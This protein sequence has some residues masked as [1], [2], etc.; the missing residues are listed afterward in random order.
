MCAM[1][2]GLQPTPTNNLAVRI[3]S[4]KGPKAAREEAL[5]RIG[6]GFSPQGGI[7]KLPKPVKQEAPPAEGKSLGNTILTGGQGGSS[8]TPAQRKSLLGS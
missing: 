1:F 3:F 2:F 4:G 7:R 5:A 8:Q 6:F